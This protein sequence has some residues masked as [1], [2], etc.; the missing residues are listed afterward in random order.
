MQRLRSFEQLNLRFNPFGELERE[1]RARVALVEPISLE[2]GRH[3][4][5]VAEAGR[6][7]STHLTA[8]QH[9]NPTYP[10]TLMVGRL[11]PGRDHRFPFSV[12][13]P[14]GPV[15][16]RGEILN[17]DWTLR[18]QADIPW[19]IDPRTEEMLYVVGASP[20]TAYVAGDSERAAIF[21]EAAG[22]D[23]P[24]GCLVAVL[25]PFYL[26]GIG[27][28]AAGLA[29][30]SIVV[31]LVSLAFF[32]LPSFVMYGFLKNRIAGTRIGPVEV[33]APEQVERG[34]TLEAKMTL[35][36][37]RAV[38]VNAITASLKGV[39]W[40]E[41][42]SGTNRTTHVRT[43]VEQRQELHLAR[44]DLVPNVPLAVG[45][46]FSL[47]DDATLSFAAR[48]NRLEWS[49]EFHIDIPNWPDA[50]HSAAFLVVPNKE[51]PL[52]RE[53]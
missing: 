28:I 49:V 39:E 4:Q 42:G 23:L 15:T 46:S 35:N 19:R 11:I 45:H 37:K 31:A 7:K 50:T 18:A 20:D 25:G 12:T 22:R 44:P 48:D 9:A 24:L 21:R 40:C 29:I 30:N 32:G 6:G 10:L 3:I 14:N 26:A 43:V 2:R 38:R 5:I 13:V 52:S 8:W 36:P 34:D 27:W 16:Y 53:E 17:V 47:P 1:S 33:E 41:S 51:I